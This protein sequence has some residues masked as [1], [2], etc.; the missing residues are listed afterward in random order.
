MK[1]KLEIGDKIA[2]LATCG[3]KAVAIL[4]VARVTETLA[5]CKKK[6]LFSDDEYEIKFPREVNDG[7][8]F[9]E[10]GASDWNKDYYTLAVDE[11]YKQI[12][13][14][15]IRHKMAKTEWGTVPVEKLEKI[16]KILEQ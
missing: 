9:T 10:K 13:T 1:K 14:A 11:H 15:N 12:Y 16:Q 8:C 5:V 7:A 2:R 3:G 6:A 4:A